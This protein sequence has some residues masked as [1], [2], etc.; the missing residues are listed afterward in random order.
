[1]DLSQGNQVTPITIRDINFTV[2]RQIEQCPKTMMLRELVMNAIEAAEE[3]PE[4]RRHVEIKG[5]SVPECGDARKLAIWNAGPGMTSAELDHICDLAA[6]LG[7]DMALEG[8]FGMGAK[9]ASLPS[10]TL[11]MRYRSCR[12]GVVSQV[13]LGKREGIYGKILTP[14]ED[15]FE[16]VV[17]VTDIVRDEGEYDLGEDW[18][19][20]VLFGQHKDQ[21]TV[22]DPYDGDP[23]QDRQWIT[24]YLYHRFYR[25]PGG[26]DVT[27]QEG[28]HPRDGHRQFKTIPDRAGSFG[29]CDPVDAGGG[30]T[31]HYYYDPP[32]QDGGHNKSISGSLTSSVST[33]AIVFKG[34]MFD[35]RKGRRWAADAPAFGIPFGARHISVHVELPDAF[36]VRHEPYRRFVQLATGDQRQLLV[37]D[38][39]ELVLRNRPAWLIEIINS[40]A[41]K[42]SASTDDLRKELQDLLNELRVKAQSPRLAVGG[43]ELVED[44]GARGASPS[45][46][47]DGGGSGGAAPVS[48][49]D[50]IFNPTG[51]KRAT[52]SKNLEQA[53]E[54]IPLRDEQDIADKNIVGKAARYVRE[55]N[56]LFVNLTYSAVAN[57]QE[58]LELR[59]AVYEDLELV[60]EQ[61]RQW[62]ERLVMGRI[63]YAVIYAQAKQLI[64]EWTSDDVKKALEPE[65]LSLAADGWRDAVSNAYRVLSRKFGSNK[66]SAEPEELEEATA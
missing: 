22:A 40:L 65:S 37:E 23:K 53:P 6:S 33:S 31:I 64:R 35:V 7:K 15:L 12:D 13:V 28:T 59:Y 41:P 60:R 10:N 20:V 9:V 57:A 50:L 39:A 19:E 61:A 51:A 21:D 45:R 49:T 54:I 34:E 5:K 27:L 38:F 55:T 36:P 46:G 14:V 48:P 62:A 18:T 42:S 66:A 43:L 3:A 29:N 1:M 4:G 32:Y 2:A 47:N 8:N 56:Q 30:V 16:E 63:G 44:G 24:T 52:I 25:L 11:G 58:H 17:D 26:V